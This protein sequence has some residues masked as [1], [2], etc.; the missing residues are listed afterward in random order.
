MQYCP[1]CGEEVINPVGSNDCDY[2]IIE[3]FSELVLPPPA[4]TSRWQ[5]NDWTPRKILVNELAKVG[6]VLQQF[7]IVS[8]Y[9]HLTPESGQPN[10]DCYATGLS[11]AMDE[12]HNKL[13][14]IIL[15]T[16]LCKEFTGYELKQVCG[17]SNVPY[18]LGHDTGDM[19]R[20]FLPTI[21]SIYSTGSGEFRIGLQRFVKQLGVE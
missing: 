9:P 20:V 14:I 17:L 16:N 19:P 13:G 6:M 8:V 4:I 15:G 18:L 11:F 21:R 5:K 3:E 12:I 10:E 2:L 1:V 7:R